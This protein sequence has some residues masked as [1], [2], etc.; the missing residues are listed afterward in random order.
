MEEDMLIILI[1]SMIFNFVAFFEFWVFWA[2][3]R[4][5]YEGLRNYFRRHRGFGYVIIRYPEG[6]IVKHFKKISGGEL[7][8]FGNKSY[9]IKSDRI[10]YFEGLPSLFYNYNDSMPIDLASLKSDDLWRNAEW[11]NNLQMNI[12]AAAE[13]KAAARHQLRELLLYVSCGLGLLSL[14][15]ISYVLYLL[16]GDAGAAGGVIVARP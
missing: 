15:A 16:T 2:M 3:A 12:K 13:A 5:Q 1:I 9:A 10:Y 8:K 14:V 4:K 6:R 7:I 11:Q